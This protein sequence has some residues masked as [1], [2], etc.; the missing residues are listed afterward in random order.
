MTR[1]S[2]PTSSLLFSPK[3]H[4]GSNPAQ[5]Q[6][7]PGPHQRQPIHVLR[8]DIHCPPLPRQALLEGREGVVGRVGPAGAR[9]L[10]AVVVKLL[11]A[12]GLGWVGLGWVA[13][14]LVGVLK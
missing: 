6:T 3:N 8:D 14:L 13:L 12:D 5:Q 4:P 11:A 7:D 1:L 2:Q 9:D 10:A